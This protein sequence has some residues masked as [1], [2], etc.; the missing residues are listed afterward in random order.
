M[1]EKKL[2]VGVAGLWMGAGHI[3]AYKAMPNA[4]VVA[5]CDISE[6][7]LKQSQDTYDVPRGFTNYRDMFPDA[8]LDAV[9]LA[10]PTKLH[11]EATIEA[12]K[13][14]K[15]VLVEKPMAVTTEEAR[16]MA[17]VAKKTG[18]TLMV[19][20]NQ[21]FEPEVRFLKR[22]IQ[23]GGLGDIYFARTVW[24]RPLGMSPPPTLDRSTGAYDRNWFNEAKSGGGVARD[25]GSHIIDIAMWLMG[26]PEIE[27]VI[28]RGFTYSCHSRNRIRGARLT[29]TIIRWA[30]FDLQME[31]ACRSRLRSDVISSRKA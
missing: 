18:K 5:L 29:R 23:E 24:R 14:G 22:Y 10:L 15:H 1:S 16:R 20:Y 31:P 17:E 13:A 21:R 19:S 4:E 3:A 7:W 30:L 27:S 26:F 25:L 12:L 9:S 6:P 2:K 11:A 28:G 8:D